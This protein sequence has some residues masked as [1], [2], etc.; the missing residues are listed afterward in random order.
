MRTIVRLS[1]FARLSILTGFLLVFARLALADGL[2]LY[3]TIP[4]SLPPNL[5]SQAYE[6]TATS[7]LGGLIQFAGGGSSYSLTSATVEMSDWALA[8]DYPSIGGSGFSLPLT[9]NLYSVGANNSVGPS[10]ASVTVNA[11]IP[12]RPAPSGGCGAGYLGSDGNCYHGSLSAVTFNLSGLSASGEI[13]YG[14]S[15]NTTDYGAAPTAVPGPYDSLNF[16]L[17]SASPSAG[18]NPLPDTAYIDSLNSSVYGDDAGN[19]GSFGPSTGWSPYSPAIEF[20]GEADPAGG[21]NPAVTPEPSSLLLLGSGLFGLS[22]LL[23]RRS[24]TCHQ[25]PHL[26]RSLMTGPKTPS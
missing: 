17:S 10:F 20:D 26:Q 3:S 22:I 24:R 11:F 15:F 13:I 9:L 2:V 1:F 8:S 25:A 4:A 14:L 21:G 18:G 12:W 23:L 7:E 19:V 16:A 6:A 5:P